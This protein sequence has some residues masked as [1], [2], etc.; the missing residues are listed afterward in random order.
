MSFFQNVFGQEYQGYLNTGNDRQYSLTFKVAANKNNQDYHFG[1]NPEPFDFSVNN[2]LT[3]NYAWDT[4]FRN[5]SSLP[6]NI[7]GATPA[8][9][10]ALEVVT[11][12]NAD[13]TFS[14]MYEAQVVNKNQYKH[15]LITSKIARAKQIIKMYVSNSSAETLIRFNKYAGVSELPTY[16]SRDTID[17][18]FVYENSLNHLIELDES[19]SVDQN[20]ITDA[21]FD[22]S[23]M[24]EDWQLL[25]GRGAGIYTFKKQT[26]D[27]SSRITEIIEYPAGAVVGDL[28]RKTIMT[29]TGAKT[30]PDEIFQIPYVL[31]SGDLIV[32]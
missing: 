6:I 19:D 16:F 24:K 18:R 21:G 4:D 5:W 26:V 27:A 10:T 7:S 30:E 3:L 14:S 13:V 11:A 20:I 23:A 9:T 12:L 17:N 22:Y 28:S 32:P 2:I 15:V 1:W 25:R 8:A 29:Y 31:T